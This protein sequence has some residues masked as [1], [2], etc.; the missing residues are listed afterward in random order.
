MKNH[1]VDFSRHKF[2]SNVV[3]KCLEFGDDSDRKDLVARVV[4]DAAAPQNLKLLL[5]DPF[6]NYVVQK[7]VDLADRD[8]VMTIAA[9]LRPCGRASAAHARQAH[10]YQTGEEGAGPQTLNVGATTLKTA[11]P[12]ATG[13][14][15]IRSR[16]NQTPAPHTPCTY[17]Q[18]N[19]AT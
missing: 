2:A 16:E 3:E 12:L 18:R 13:Y 8:Q 10:H 9:A 1:L 11:A 6:A 19:D 4:G 5:V 17:M 7:V 14:L 15:Y